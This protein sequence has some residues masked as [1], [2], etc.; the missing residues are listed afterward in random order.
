MTLSISLTLTLVVCLSVLFLRVA[1]FF[2]ERIILM[3]T[4][5]EAF[6]PVGSV[7]RL[8]ISS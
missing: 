5:P 3:Q 2:H 8:Y 7:A 1:V 6:F 4:N